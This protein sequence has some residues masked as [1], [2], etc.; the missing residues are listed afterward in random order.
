MQNEELRNLYTYPNE[1]YRNDQ[2]K[3]GDIGEACSTCKSEKLICLIVTPERKGP[4]TRLGHRWKHD[5]EIYL[6]IGY[7]GT[8]RIYL[9]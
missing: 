5:I 7:E 6:I 4:F 3:N 1:Y 2:I 8:C 9:A